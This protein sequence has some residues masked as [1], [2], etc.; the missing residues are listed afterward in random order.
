MEC[1]VLFQPARVKIVG[2]DGGRLLIMKPQALAPL[3]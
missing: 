2:K 1:V 3:D